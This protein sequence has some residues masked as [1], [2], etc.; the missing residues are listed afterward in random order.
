MVQAPGIMV[1]R[2]TTMAGDLAGASRG[3][4]MARRS[5]RALIGISRVLNLAAEG[6]A[7]KKCGK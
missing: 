7:A 5:R 6:E 2:D 4:L 1:S 3:I